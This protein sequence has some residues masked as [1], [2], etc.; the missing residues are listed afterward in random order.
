MRI[1]AALSVALLVAACSTAQ[2]TKSASR[3]VDSVQALGPKLQNAST[4][5]ALQ[6]LL[7]SAATDFHTHP[8]TEPA[9][10]R[11]VRFGHLVMPGG[12]KQYRLCGQFLPAHGGEKAQWTPFATIKTSGYEQWIGSLAAWYCQDSSF[13]L[14]KEGD[15]SVLLQNR[16]NSLR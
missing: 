13:V 7:T 12:D 5:S 4:D 10:F 6:F 2:V 14:D 16:L 9:G 3:A 8:L 15:L 11:N 1:L